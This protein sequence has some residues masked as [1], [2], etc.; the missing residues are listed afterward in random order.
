M[1]ALLTE[2]GFANHMAGQK[3]LRSEKRRAEQRSA[4]RRYRRAR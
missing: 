3:E 2:L 1:T 4:F